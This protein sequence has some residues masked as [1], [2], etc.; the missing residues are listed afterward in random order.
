[1]DHG[2]RPFSLQETTRRNQRLSLLLDQELTRFHLTV[3]QSGLIMNKKKHLLPD[4]RE[5]LK[6]KNQFI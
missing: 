3:G 6:S 1:M 4:G 5:F 2:G